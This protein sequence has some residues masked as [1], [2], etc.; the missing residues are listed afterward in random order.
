[1][2]H[3]DFLDPGTAERLL[4]GSVA[5]AD[6]PPGFGPVAEL[7]DAARDGVTPPAADLGALASAARAGASSIGAPESSTPGRPPVLAK[8]LTLKAAAVAGVV[9]LGATSAAAATGALPGPLQRTAHSTLSH[10]GVDVPSDDDATDATDVNGHDATEVEDST[11]T[12]TTLPGDPNAVPAVPAGTPG[13]DD[14]TE[15]QGQPEIEDH[16]GDGQ[17]QDPADDQGEDQGDDH[18]GTTATTQPGSNSGPG[19]T[20]SG[21]GEDGSGDS[22]SGGH[23]GD[24]GSGSGS[25]GHGGGE[26]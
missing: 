14:A 18:G 13:A 17:G 19:S 23:G 15:H 24:S 4:D 26:D 10:V 12:T 1:M 16:S 9:L 8:F 6:A 5:P 25:G 7:L 20:S 22:G 21:S 11:T 3:D 2:T